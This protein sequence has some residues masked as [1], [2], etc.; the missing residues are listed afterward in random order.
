MRYLVHIVFLFMSI[1][2]PVVADELRPAEKACLK[3]INEEVSFVLSGIEAVNREFE[4]RVQRDKLA[5]FKAGEYSGN[6]FLDNSIRKYRMDITGKVK[7]WPVKYQSLA[8]RRNETV[9]CTA[10]QLQHDAVGIIHDF[11]VNW[12]RVVQKAQQNQEFFQSIR[13]LQ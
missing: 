7:A 4:D 10:Q 11:E 2:L 1:N 9:P 8:S 13:H 6:A 12:D 3:K 5:E